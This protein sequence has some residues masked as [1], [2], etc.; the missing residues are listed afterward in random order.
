M[1]LVI[2]MEAAIMGVLIIKTSAESK[3]RSGRLGNMIK[4][5]QTLP[6]S[7]FQADKVGR[8]K[9]LPFRSANE[10]RSSR[11]RRRTAG[12]LA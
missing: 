12:L 11:R 7:A 6:S 4:L 8:R 2:M 5:G 10:S 9:V 1:G 3:R